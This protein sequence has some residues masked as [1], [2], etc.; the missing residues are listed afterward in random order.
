MGLREEAD[1][2]NVF[3]KKGAQKGIRGASKFLA[4]TLAILKD[5]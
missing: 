5:A 4:I 3:S 2:G 1:Y